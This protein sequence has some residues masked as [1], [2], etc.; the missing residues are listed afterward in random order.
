[1]ATPTKQKQNRTVYGV[2]Q[3]R[4]LFQPSICLRIRTALC[5]QYAIIRISRHKNLAGGFRKYHEKSENQCKNRSNNILQ[6]KNNK[7]FDRTDKPEPQRRHTNTNAV[8][9]LKD[10]YKSRKNTS[11]QHTKKSG[12][13]TPYTGCISALPIY[14]NYAYFII[15]L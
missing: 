7:F 6:Q 3:D 13:A 5:V 8:G 9:I 4:Q 2:L 10:I 11:R 1:M 14:E 15:N 12:Y